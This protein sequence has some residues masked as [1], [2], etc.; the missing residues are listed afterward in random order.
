[1][2]GPRWEGTVP[3]PKPTD[4]PWPHYFSTSCMHGLH[5]VCKG[6]C[7]FCPEKCRCDCHQDRDVDEVLDSLADVPPAEQEAFLQG[8]RGTL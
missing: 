3:I 5:E 8:L 4:G 2:T 7:K 1:V 6:I